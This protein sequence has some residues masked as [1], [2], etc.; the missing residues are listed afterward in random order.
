[1][2]NIILKMLSLPLLCAAVMMSCIKDIS[3]SASENGLP[4]KFD[5]AVSRTFTSNEPDDNISSLRVIAIDGSGRVRSNKRYTT[6]SVQ[7]DRITHSMYTGTY[8]F[9]FLANEPD[10][11]NNAL[12]L[13]ENLNQI[14]AMSI[15]SG[16]FNE[17]ADI[18]MVVQVEDVQV[19]PENKGVII[20][21]LTGT[22]LPWTL[23]LKRLAIRFDMDL[24]S[25]VD[26]TLKSVTFT[27]LPDA[28]PL[29][30]TEYKGT[31][32]SPRTY[33]VGTH[34]DQITTGL[35]PAQ[36]M[37]WAAN[38]GRVIL[39][40]HL[41]TPATGTERASKVLLTLS[42][43]SQR[44]HSISHTEDD[45]SSPL[46][47]QKHYNLC[48][49][50][51]FI[52]NGTIKVNDNDFEMTTNVLTWDQLPVSANDGIHY[53]W[54]SERKLA[55]SVMND[56]KSVILKTNYPGWSARVY[57]D[58]ACT[59]DITS[60]G[61]LTVT[62]SSEASATTGGTTVDVTSD[63]PALTAYIKFTAGRMAAIVEITQAAIPTLTVTGPAS[64]YTYEGGNQTF[65][66]T[67]YTTYNGTDTPAAW[68]AE[69]SENGGTT[70]SATVPS[71]LIRFTTRDEG[72]TTATNYS[73]VAMPLPV[74]VT[75]PENDLLKAAAVVGTSGAPHDLSTNGGTTP[76]N[77]ANCYVINAPGYYKLP[78]VYGNARKNGANN[79]SAYSTSVTGAYILQTFKR[80]DNNNITD[81]YIYNNSGV[82]PDNAT[83]VWMDAPGLIANVRLTDDNHSLAFDVP[84]GSIAQGNAIVAVRNA[85]NIILW[86]WHIWVTATTV[87]NVASPETDETE[88]LSAPARTFN[89]MKYNLGWCNMGTTYC[90]VGDN[91]DQPRSVLVRISQT[92]IYDPMEVTFTITQ[93]NMVPT[94]N[95]NNPYWQWGRK[96]PMPPRYGITTYDTEKT[97]YVGVEYVYIY[98]ATPGSVTLGT[99]IANPNTFYCSTSNGWQESKL[100]NLWSVNNNP[101]TLDFD[102]NMPVKTVYDPSPVGFVVPPSGAWSGF[103]SDGASSSASSKWNVRDP[104]DKG[105]NFHL[106]LNKN[107]ATAFYPA[108]NQ[109][110]AGAAVT[111]NSIYGYYW[112]ASAHNSS[113]F[114][115]Y[116]Y[117]L[118]FT[119][120][121]INPQYPTYPATGMPIRSVKED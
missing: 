53:L 58:A 87:F 46:D 62:P 3:S 60:T 99:A 40:S 15:P 86:S 47:G 9:I 88:N 64:N 61:W 16:Y 23:A 121:Y 73:A 78:L 70:W 68:K 25:E 80:H 95:V 2:K 111:P 112:S 24:Q 102:Y 63:N 105:W 34:T 107:G 39:P 66:V 29:L 35:T 43:N 55:L 57:S 31:A 67:S 6:T 117:S 33:T 114:A 72:G 94:T 5:I 32:Y 92:G 69:F 13:V 38:V 41:F 120:Y 74:V 96:D 4:A 108:T 10:G 110:T 85:S 27:N 21:G 90:G 1:M 44:E 83:L 19:L 84:K 91:N 7:G 14:K 26:L 17:A 36:D 75:R 56:T 22:Q 71:W 100:I 109:R 79:T 76:E 116:A 65:S 42:D 30:G 49:N 18:P 59:D 45:A 81:P 8:R 118:S 37:K 106:K 54:V 28:V 50:H 20:P 51:R 101:S 48:P 77:T 113:N 93:D 119:Y 103:T 89:F 82:V 11:M 98:K 115:T 12:D 52:I 104:F 97:L